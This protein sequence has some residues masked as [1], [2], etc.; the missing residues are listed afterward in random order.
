MIAACLSSYP[1]ISMCIQ[2]KRWGV[3]LLIS[4]KHPGD[5]LINPDFMETHA[6]LLQLDRTEKDMP[7]K[8]WRC[9]I[10][11]WLSSHS[12][13]PPS[14]TG[15]LVLSARLCSLQR[16]RNVLSCSHWH[17]QCSCDTL[18]LGVV[19]LCSLY[20]D[21]GSVCIYSIDF[22]D[23]DLKWSLL[24]EAVHKK[25]KT[26]LMDHQSHYLLMTMLH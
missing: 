11:S 23:I 3:Y 10:N 18:A 19:W 14:L 4:G 16:E 25:G 24:Q 13:A 17:S 1:S 7:N 22:S 20:M 5:W 26:M 12:Q 21:S 2:R 9:H 8:N 6:C 15:N